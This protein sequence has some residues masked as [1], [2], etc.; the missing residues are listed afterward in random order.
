[1]QILVVDDNVD[2]ALLL[3]TWLEKAGH[4]CHH[5]SDGEAA[6]AYLKEKQP[7]LIIS[8]I[9]MPKLDGFALCRAVK[10][11]PIW[12]DIY[13]IFCTATYTDEKDASLALQLGAQRFLTK[14]VHIPRLQAVLAE[15]ESGTAGPSLPTNEPS[16][17]EPAYLQLYNERLVS[18]LEENYRQSQTAVVELRQQNEQLWRLAE[19]SQ[20]L[21]ETIAETAMTQRMVQQM[22]ELMQ[23]ETALLVVLDGEDL[24]I[25]Q[26]AGRYSNLLPGL[27]LPA[28]DTLCAGTL[29]RRQFLTLDQGMRRQLADELL[30]ADVPGSCVLAP[31]HVAEK[32]LGLLVALHRQREKFDASILQMGQVWTHQAAVA[33]ENAR[34]IETL[35]TQTEVLQLSQ[36]QVVHNARMATVG[37]LTA[38][39]AHEIN[40][41][42]Q[43]ILGSV[44]FVLEEVAQ[45]WPQ[46]QYLE[47]AATE[48]HRVSDI[49]QRMVG[50]YRRDTGRLQPT[51]INDLIRETLVLAEKQLQRHHVAVI[52]DLCP[53]LP[54]IPLPPNQFKQLFLNVILNAA[55]AMPQGG[56]L[57]II[58]SDQEGEWLEVSFI[59]S[60]PGI[61]AAEL[62]RIF[63]SFY[64]T[65]PRG[66]GLGLAISRDIAR[67]HGGDLLAESIA[68]QGS[69][70]RLRLP[71]QGS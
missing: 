53:D 7:E 9:L 24:V 49:F 16:L 21:N 67:A 65:K 36:D 11:D 13:F 5:A 31:L 39:L 64:T 62:G 14:P 41:P 8:D 29:Q 71:W 35:R 34:L 58:T 6:L 52:T 61:P 50:F 46:R 55:D 12:R 69:T 18:K 3:L 10:R 59:D 60:G 28:S 4:H 68:G 22:L 1:M 38:A 15:I 37:R 51:F 43:S 17:A 20:S 66:T 27:V 47:L 70:F 30:L 48:L 54:A 23:A 2:D 42:L 25:T 63:E 45:D 33:W 56:Q 40:N 26:A 19:V 44:M 32:P 57:Q